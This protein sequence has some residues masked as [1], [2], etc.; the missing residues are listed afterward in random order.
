M[1][2]VEFDRYLVNYY[3]NKLDSCKKRGIAFNLTFTQVKNLMRAKK[4]QYTGVALTHTPFATQ[5]QR[6]TDVTIERIDSRKPY[7]TGNVC[8]I[9]FAANQAKSGFDAKYGADAVAMMHLISANLKKRGV[10]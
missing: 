9:S 6:D 10:K 1:D 4:C 7:E 3:M 2:K 8:A 5:T